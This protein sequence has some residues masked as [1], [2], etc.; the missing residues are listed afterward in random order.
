MWRRGDSNPYFWLERP[1][2]DR[3][4]ADEEHIFNVH[5]TMANPPALVDSPVG[6]NPLR[7]VSDC[8]VELVQWERTLRSVRYRS[9]P[10]AT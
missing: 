3:Y 7:L 6:G 9:S 5:E 8:E 1:L 10:L 2:R 4:E